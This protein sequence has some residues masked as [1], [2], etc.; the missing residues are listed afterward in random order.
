MALAL[1]GG[2]ERSSKKLNYHEGRHLV[3]DD[4]RE[5]IDMMIQYVPT[6]PCINCHNAIYQ[7][8]SGY[9]DINPCRCSHHDNWFRAYW[10][11]L[12]SKVEQD[13]NIVLPNGEI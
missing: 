9:Y 10:K 13:Y 8:V 1:V 4:D 6:N 2:I 3:R 7:T 12:R 5:F 11:K